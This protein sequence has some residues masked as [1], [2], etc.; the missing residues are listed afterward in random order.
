MARS[1]LTSLVSLTWCVVLVLPIMRSYSRLKNGRPGFTTQVANCNF[2]TKDISSFILM[3][4]LD[5]VFLTSVEYCFNF[6]WGSLASILCVSNSIPRNVSVVVGQTVFLSERGI[7]TRSASAMN[8]W[9]CVRHCCLFCAMNKKSSSTLTVCGTPNFV[10]RIYLIPDE[11][12]SKI[13]QED[14]HP[15]GKTLS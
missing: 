6:S 8:L 15:W 10:F 7:P 1:A 4:D 11:K 2:P 5:I 9:R 13:L 14:A 3:E 12:V